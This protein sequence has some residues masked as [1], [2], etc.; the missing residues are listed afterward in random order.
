MRQLNV[1]L[2]VTRNTWRNQVLPQ[3]SGTSEVGLWED[4]L[5]NAA[6]ISKLRAHPKPMGT[7]GQGQ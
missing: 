5:R 6:N 1:H 3:L 2:F 4:D 7:R